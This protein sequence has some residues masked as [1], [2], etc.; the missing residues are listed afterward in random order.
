MSIIEE[1]IDEETNKPIKNLRYTKLN[2]I[3]ILV[4]YC[5]IPEYD[6]L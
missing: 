2:Y 3:G 4:D 6:N 1:Y 5:I